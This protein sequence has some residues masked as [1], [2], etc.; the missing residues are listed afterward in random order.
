M[1]EREDKEESLEG[2]EHSID[3]ISIG[4][5]Q[6]PMREECYCLY[7][8]YEETTLEI[9][10][11]QGKYVTELVFKFRSLLNPNSTCLFLIPRISSWATYFFI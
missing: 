5:Y 8:I 7:F 1:K 9:L 4:S 6:T 11:L 3:I 2:T 10:S